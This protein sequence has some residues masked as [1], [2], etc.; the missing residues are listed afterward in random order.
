MQQRNGPAAGGAAQNRQRG[1]PDLPAGPVSPPVIRSSSSRAAVHPMVSACWSAV[2]SCGRSFSQSGRLPKPVIASSSGHPDAEVV[3]HIQR[4]IRKI[5]V[6]TDQSFGPVRHFQQIADLLV[7]AVTGVGDF[8]QKTAV[9]RQT[10]AEHRI[11]KPGPPLFAGTDPRKQHG[12]DLPVTALKKLPDQRCH[13][14]A[15]VGADVIEIAA[16]P[17][18][19]DQHHRIVEAVQLGDMRR[20]R[21]F[22]IGSSSSRR[23]GGG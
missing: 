22:A 4:V 10:P 9:H 1:K 7:V 5:I 8:A 20:R 11:E 18:L 6:K 2:V 14:R 23:P 3:S 16:S 17:H 19:V 15:I 13:R 12:P 21:R